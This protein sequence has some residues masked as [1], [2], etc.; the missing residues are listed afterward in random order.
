MDAVQLLPILVVLACLLKEASG[1]GSNCCGI[2]RISTIHMA[3]FHRYFT[4][5]SKTPRGN[6][7]A[8][9]TMPVFK[10]FHSGAWE[11]PTLEEHS[12]SMWNARVL[13]RVAQYGV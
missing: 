7:S 6:G 3:C 2:N 12:L 5:N 13:Q 4:A 8:S 10:D 9:V 1:I 11:L